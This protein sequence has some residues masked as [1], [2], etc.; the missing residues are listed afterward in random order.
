MNVSPELKESLWNNSDVA[1]G[2]KE[3]VKENKHSLWFCFTHNKRN[4]L[5]VTWGV[6]IDIWKESFLILRFILYICFGSLYTEVFF[7]VY[8]TFFFII[9]LIGCLYMW[10]QGRWVKHGSRQLVMCSGP[11]SVIGSRVS[12]LLGLEAEVSTGWEDVLVIYRCLFL[13]QT[14][15]AGGTVQAGGVSGRGLTETEEGC[16]RQRV[17]VSSVSGYLWWLKLGLLSEMKSRYLKIS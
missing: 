3:A 11:C 4:Y 12:E 1:S 2:F 13:S 6:R 14:G 17:F 5:L 7:N 10:P 8:I 16:G 15:T 9:L